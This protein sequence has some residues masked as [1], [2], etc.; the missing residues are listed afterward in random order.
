VVG[1]LEM[2]KV[3]VSVPSPIKTKIHM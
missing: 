2:H 3:L 1:P